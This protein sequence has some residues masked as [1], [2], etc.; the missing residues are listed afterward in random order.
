M[1]LRALGE[2]G[3]IAGRQHLRGAKAA[4]ATGTAALALA[5]GL[6]ACGGGDSQDANEPSGDFPVQAKA[7][8]P[9][10]QLLVKTSDLE[11][12][13]D[14][15]GDETIPNLAVTIHTTPSPAPAG[16]PKS[17]GAFDVRV[18]EPN[19]ADPNRP[20]W[21]LEYRYPKLIAP[22]ESPKELNKTESAGAAAAQTDTF[23]FGALRSGDSKRIVWRV[24][25]VRIGNYTVHYEIA[26]GLYGKARAVSSGGGP[27]KGEFDVTINSKP[28]ETCVKG[29][30]VT[31]Q[32]RKA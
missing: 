31:T 24:T 11:L 22:G 29:D 9:D 10:H 14:N 25:P 16:E 5:W 20:V 23:Q 27:V 19:L 15:V 17:D 12:D 32:C 26:A 28:P 1:F 8:F 4:I 7:S 2:S 3:T 21:I 30:E 13:I 18:D 6:T